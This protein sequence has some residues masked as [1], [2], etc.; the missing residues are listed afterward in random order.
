MVTVVGCYLVHSLSVAY[1]DRI[2][3][4]KPEISYQKLA[5]VLRQL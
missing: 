3:F 4:P 2:H 5:K 1:P